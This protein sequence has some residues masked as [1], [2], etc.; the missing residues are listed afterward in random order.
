MQSM[1]K[2]VHRME[3]RHAEL[4]R[5]QEKLMQVR[6]QH[7]SCMMLAH[8]PLGTSLMLHVVLRVALIMRR[9]SMPPEQR[10]PRRC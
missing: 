4:L 2:E 6:L 10:P 5:L 1:Q 3:L 8:V 9:G 7:D